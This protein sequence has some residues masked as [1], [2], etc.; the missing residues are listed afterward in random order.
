LNI[1]E[2]Q[3]STALIPREVIRDFF[4]VFCE[5]DDRAFFLGRFHD[6]LLNA[7]KAG[8]RNGQCFDFFPLSSGSDV[9]IWRRRFDSAGNRGLETNA[10]HIIP[11]LLGNSMGPS[12][13][14]LGV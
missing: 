5:D 9:V 4:H 7:G 1:F 14:S 8:P 13:L 2:G 3:G 12:A 6:L 10:L 11:F